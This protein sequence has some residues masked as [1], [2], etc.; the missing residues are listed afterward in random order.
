MLRRI[1]QLAILAALAALLQP[2]LGQA[3]YKS[4]TPDGRTVYSDKPPPDAVKVEKSTIDTSRRG[5][6]PPSDREKAALKQMQLDRK[7]RENAQDR[8]RRA[9]IA[10]HDAEV[11]A[12]MGKEPQPNERLGTAS[13]NQRLTDGYWERQKKLESNVEA[14]RLSLEKIRSGR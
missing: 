1:S 8:V 14:A 2:A 6:V 13:G 3:L 4:I 11:A 7:K 12:A 9:E 5:V 10:V